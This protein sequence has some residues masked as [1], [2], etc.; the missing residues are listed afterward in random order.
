MHKILFYIH[1]PGL[2]NSF[3]DPLYYNLN[4][5][6]KIFIFHIAS[7]FGEKLKGENYD[8]ID[9]GKKNYKD[10]IAYVRRI[11][12]TTIV[13]PGFVSIN[14]LFI[15]RIGKQLGIKVI[16]MEH[17]VLSKQTTSYPIVKIVT[18]FYAVANNNSKF[19]NN[20]FQYILCSKNKLSEARI[21]ISSI[22]KRNYSRTKFDHAMFYSK[23]S[24]MIINKLFNYND[25]QISISGTPLFISNSDEDIARKIS[26]K[27]NQKT[28]LYIHQPFILDGISKIDY[29]ME[30]QYI[31]TLKKILDKYKIRLNML[32]HPR[33]SISLYESLYSCTNIAISYYNNNYALIKN[34]KY[35]FGHYSTLLMMALYFKKY[36]FI[37]PYPKLKFGAE[38][39]LNYSVNIENIDELK[40]FDIFSSDLMKVN[41]NSKELFTNRSTFESVAN[42]LLDVINNSVGST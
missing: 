9:I 41:Q 32:L 10:I 28:A 1:R 29:A 22:L 34:C 33:E 17:G 40:D 21:L 20:Y 36:I 18:S 23:Y 31:L 25:N 16:Y 12:P 3:V 19:L 30:K 11:N 42:T 6:A 35:I 8:C 14:E 4:K 38:M 27:N 7:L 39:Y 13:I 2:I 26:T 5:K 24:Y 37:I 15:L